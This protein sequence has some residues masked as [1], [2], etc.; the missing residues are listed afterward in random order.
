[1]AH[2]IFI[3]NGP[4]LNLLGV[5]EPEIYGRQTL[6]DIEALTKSHAA[7][8]GLSV[9]FRQSNAEGVLIDSI[10]EA[11]DAASGVIINAG[12][13]SHT[14]IALLDALLS[15]SQPIIEV[16]L[17]N[18]FK[19]EAFRHHSYVSAA[20]TGMICGLGA[21]GYVLALDALHR[22]LMPGGAGVK[23]AVD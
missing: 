2:P 22:I 18:L 20:A 21:Q 14:S 12:A 23:S 1:M 5:R 6:A 13:Y 10:H 3:L 8:L 19:R 17:S 9:D 16:H 7:K 11:R 4:N 15:V